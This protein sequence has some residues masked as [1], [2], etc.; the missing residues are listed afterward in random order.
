MVFSSLWGALTGTSIPNQGEEKC[1]VAQKH[2]KRV[3]FK[4]IYIIL[5]IAVKILL[6]FKVFM[7]GVPGGRSQIKEEQKVCF[8]PEN[9][10]H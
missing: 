2:G 4:N 1:T 10:D 7:P 9:C 5:K 6:L 8:G 3:L